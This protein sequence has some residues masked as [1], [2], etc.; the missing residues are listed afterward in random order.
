MIFYFLFFLYLVGYLLLVCF[1]FLSSFSLYS[2][3]FSR[4]SSKEFVCF[5]IIFHLEAS[6]IVRIMAEVARRKQVD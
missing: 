6:Q 2:F 5:I 4:M 1:F 3:F